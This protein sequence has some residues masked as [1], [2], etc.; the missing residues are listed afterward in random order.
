MKKPVIST[1][2]LI[3]YC[4]ILVKVMVFKDIPTIRVGGLMLNFA[5][6]NAGHA[7]NFVPFKTI[8]PY[9]LG[10][11]G[12]IIAGVN[13]VGNIALLVPIGLLAPFVYRSMTWKASLALGVA[14][15]LC[16]EVMQTVLVVGIFDIDDVILNALGVMIGYAAFAL[17]AQ[18]IR[19]RNYKKVAI[20]AA[21]A[22]AAA[23]AF[24]GGVVY[25]M[26]HQP[27]NPLRDGGGVQSD[28]SDNGGDLCGGTG[29]TG[30]IASKGNHTITIKRK[31]GVI[32]ALALT[33]RTTIRTSAGPASESDL[34]TGDRV[35]V[36]VYDRET[37]TTVLKCK[38]SS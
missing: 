9:L 12:W 6:T 38:D 29:G 18:W 4:A 33:D 31:D 11:K 28:R 14:A 15:A 8:V 3:A 2:V 5:G 32:Q 7:P 27:V 19:S 21:T 13:L 35:T 20:A 34:K 37:A 26:I 17:L 30:Q 22:V 24:Y 1:L 25:P 10:F 36:V 16:I 23:A